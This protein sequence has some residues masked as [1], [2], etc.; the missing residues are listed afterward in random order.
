MKISHTVSKIVVRE[1]AKKGR[2]FKQELISMDT[3]DLQLGVMAD[4]FWCN[5]ELNIRLVKIPT[6]L[7]IAGDNGH[8]ILWGKNMKTEK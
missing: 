4:P 1:V 3:S 5:L 8:N 7:V 6:N 2:Q